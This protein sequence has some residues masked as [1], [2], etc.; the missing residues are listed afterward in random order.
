[1]WEVEKK[2]S[3]SRRDQEEGLRGGVR[4]KGSVR[5]EFGLSTEKRGIEEESREKGGGPEGRI[6]GKWS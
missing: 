3:R 6:E 1:M 5:K 4:P 2:R